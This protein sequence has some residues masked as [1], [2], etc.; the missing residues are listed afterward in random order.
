L[1]IDCA[2][3]AAWRSAAG[4]DEGLRRNAPLTL[5]GAKIAA[6]LRLP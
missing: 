6:T 4:R 3:P 5:I 2:R 1:R